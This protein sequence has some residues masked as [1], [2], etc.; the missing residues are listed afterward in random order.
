MERL[1]P[2][3]DSKRKKY[4]SKSASTISIVVIILLIGCKEWFWQEMLDN[5]VFMLF[6]TVLPSVTYYNWLLTVWICNEHF[7]RVFAKQLSPLDW[8]LICTCRFNDFGIDGGPAGKELI[9]KFTFF[10][11][12][13][14]SKIG[15]AVPDIDVRLVCHFSLCNNSSF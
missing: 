14:S 4:S 2:Y 3:K 8:H 13:L 7:F 11:Q 9:P 5:T 1:H 10:K 6:N 15:V 12:N